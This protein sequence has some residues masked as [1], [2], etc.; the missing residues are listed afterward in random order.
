[1]SPKS[2]IAPAALAL[3][4]AACNGQT[5]PPAENPPIG[6]IEPTCNAEQFVSYVGTPAN[7]ATIA[8]IQAKRGNKAIRVIKPGMAVTM[9]YRADR[10]NVD[11]D[12]TGTI[13]RF[14]CS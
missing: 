4:L 7:D 8:A 11:V 2:I 6:A 14:Y 9:D 13:K 10:L 3:S 5:P 1:M 12:D